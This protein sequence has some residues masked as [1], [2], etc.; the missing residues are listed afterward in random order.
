MASYLRASKEE[1]PQR[2]VQE[3][4]DA[5]NTHDLDSFLGCYLLPPKLGRSSRPVRFTGRA[6]TDSRVAR[7]DPTEARC[8]KVEELV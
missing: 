8:A 4:V 7:V 1:F 6:R 2:V 5:W 3:Q